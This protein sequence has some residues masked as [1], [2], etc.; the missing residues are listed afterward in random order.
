MAT[1]G[2]RGFPKELRLAD[3]I[4]LGMRTAWKNIPGMSRF[5]DHKTPPKAHSSGEAVA[6]KVNRGRRGTRAEE[7]S[8]RRVP[9]MLNPAGDFVKVLTRLSILSGDRR[10][11]SSDCFRRMERAET[12]C[13]VLSL[14]LKNWPE[15][16]KMLKMDEG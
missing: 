11:L 1:R 9:V 6:R 14:N 15:P 5:S 13:E 8:R 3:P 12:K 2:R 4:K 7:A 10:W 16:K